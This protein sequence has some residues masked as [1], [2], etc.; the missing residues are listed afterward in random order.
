MRTARQSITWT[1]LYYCLLLLTACNSTPPQQNLTAKATAT[2]K[3]ATPTPLVPTA[4]VTPVPP[5]PQHYHAKVILPGGAR[6]DD[7]AF[8]TQGRI[9]FSDP[10]NN[11]VA[12][13]NADGSFTTLLSG[14]DAPEGLVVLPNGTLIVA[15]QGHNRILSF[16]PGSTT[17]T[18]LRVLPGTPGSAPCKDGVDGIALDPT[19]NTLIVPDSPTGVVYRLSLDGKTLTELASGIVRPVGATVDAHG[20]IYVADECGGALWRITPDGSKVRYGGFGMPDDVVLDQSGDALVIDLAI[21]VHALIRLNLATGQHTM[22]ARQGFIEPQGL[23]IDTHGN[24]FVSDD[25]A[26]TIM[27]YIPA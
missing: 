10:H 9:L 1:L 4:T 18:V 24:I 7:L 5:P 11:I 23:L 19:N 12:R 26:N 20:N 17:P 22:L 13:V 25:Y 16:A 8:D 27:E 15:E 14:L 21:N 3:V 6:P 2:V